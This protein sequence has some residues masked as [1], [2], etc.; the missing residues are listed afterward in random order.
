MPCRS[1]EEEAQIPESPN[2]VTPTKP[3]RNDGGGYDNLD[4]EFPLTQSDEEQE[5]RPKQKRKHTYVKR[6]VTGERAV[7]PEDDIERE[8]FEEARELMHL[9]GLKKLPGHKGPDT[10]LHLW[11]NA[12]AGHKTRTG[13][14]YTIYCCPLRH[15]CKCMKTIRVGRGRGLLIL[16]RYGLHDVHSHDEDGSKYLKYD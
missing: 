6:W 8:L 1:D 4:A 10:D 13:M 5:E 14:A 15:R 2:P 11:K 12:R 16:E 9:S 3:P 7:L